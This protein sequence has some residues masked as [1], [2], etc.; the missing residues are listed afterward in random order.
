[1]RHRDIY[2]RETEKY[3][4]TKKQK[5]RKLLMPS[6]HLLFILKDIYISVEY[7]PTVAGAKIVTSIV[8][9]LK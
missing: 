3:T 2:K 9:D 4:N 1:M 6:Y 5:K 7:N 8:D